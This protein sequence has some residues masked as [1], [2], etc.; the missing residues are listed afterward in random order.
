MPSHLANAYG[1]LGPQVGEATPP[2]PYKPLG[3]LAGALPH[4]QGTFSLYQELGPSRHFPLAAGA[5]SLE[6]L[7]TPI[8]S[9]C[10]LRFSQPTT[11]S[12]STFHVDDNEHLTC[13][14]WSSIEEVMPL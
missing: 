12:S 13:A 7:Q 9:T 8:T 1:G 5:R 4:R 3:L 10:G 11:L 6:Q 2:H 14:I